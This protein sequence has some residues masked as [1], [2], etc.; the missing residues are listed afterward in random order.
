MKQ[1][2]YY[3]F[4]I[5]CGKK[6]YF[7]G[8]SLLKTIFTKPKD[9][10]VSGEDCMKIFN[11]YCLRIENIVVLCFSHGYDVDKEGFAKLYEEQE[12]RMKSVKPL[13]HSS[14]NYY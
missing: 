6:C 8:G 5:E 2:N 13:I 7:R 10:P 14:V 4:K 11:T 9:I 3:E 12:N 1:D